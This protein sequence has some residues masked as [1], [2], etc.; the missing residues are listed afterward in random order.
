MKSLF[1][2]VA[3]VGTGDAKHVGTISKK[4]WEYDVTVAIP[5]LDTLDALKA[6]IAVIRAQS[7]SCYILIV[8]TGSPPEVMKRVRELRAPDLE[9]HSIAAHAYR[10]SSEPVTMALDLA[11]ALCRTPLLFHTHADCFLRRRDFLENMARVC[12]ANTPAI[13]YRMSPR[14][15]ITEEWQ[16]MV[17]H[18][19]LMLYMPSIYRVGATW[20]FQRMHYQFGYDWV[21]GGGWPD[22]EVGF[23]HC[24]RAAGIVPVFIGHDRNYERQVDDNIDHVRSYPGSKVYAKEMFKKSEGDM[25]AAIAEAYARAAAWRK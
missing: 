13:G 21:I 5:H 11:H 1:S 18:S 20:D 16:W 4:P 12:N 25:R 2:L 24:L 8:D 9:V 6:S 23:N 22:T 17:G 15:W 7:V 14:D 19:A 10:H 3:P